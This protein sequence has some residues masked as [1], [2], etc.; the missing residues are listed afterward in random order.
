MRT[1]LLL[2][3]SFFICISQVKSQSFV[4]E[5]KN[6]RTLLN[7]KGDLFFDPVTFVPGFE[8][9]KNSGKH[10]IYAGQIWIG[11]SDLATGKT[12]SS[13][14]TYRQT[15]ESWFGG[16]ISQIYTGFYDSVFHATKAQV[17][18]H[19]ANY[20]NPGY[21]PP[22]NFSF[23]PAKGIVPNGEPTNMAPFKDLNG[24]GEYS[25]FDGDHPKVIGNSSAYV[26][27]NDARDSIPPQGNPCC[28]GID[29]NSYIYDLSYVDPSLENT[30]FMNYK[31][32]NRSNRTYEDVFFGIWLD[33][34]LGDWNDD[35]IGCDTSS[36]IFFVYNGDNDDDLPN[37]Y[38]INPPA[39][40]IVFLSDPLYSFM[41]YQGTPDSVDGSPVTEED[42]YN[43]LSARWRD[44]SHLTYGAD[45]LDTTNPETNFLYSGH[46]WTEEGEGN[47]AGDRRMVGSV[48]PFTLSP[49]DSVCLDAAMLFF[50]D[51]SVNNF[52]NRDSL[53]NHAKSIRAFYDE[54]SMSCFNPFPSLASI[55]TDKTNFRFDVYPNPSHEK[56][57]VHLKE[58]TSDEVEILIY[59]E[60]GR[61]YLKLKGADLGPKVELNLGDLPSG[62]YFIQLSSSLGVETKKLII[63]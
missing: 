23:W 24:D 55:A 58:P 19:L 56:A 21:I 34:D 50:W 32:I 57:I 31:L 47:L 63:E 44:G 3:L 17:T 13:G 52:Q 60:M 42:F 8:I 4:F 62:L 53:I 16:P 9:P 20:T 10:S 30:L 1:W 46:G 12:L 14:Q 29:V 51:N 28:M 26:I 27:F 40:G 6:L 45:G 5:T 39:Q 2:Y 15:V 11:G 41:A 18:N 35:Y 43:Y 61:Q 7:H 33:P 22:T 38:G 48:G 37:G 36:N 54:N 25:P 59:D 49:G